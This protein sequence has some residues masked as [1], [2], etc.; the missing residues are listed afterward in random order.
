M[1]SF[2]TLFELFDDVLVEH[3]SLIQWLRREPDWAVFLLLGVALYC[4]SKVLR[5][6]T[7]LL[8]VS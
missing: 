8:N 6:R 2:F 1:V 4:T 3:E 5:R 7:S